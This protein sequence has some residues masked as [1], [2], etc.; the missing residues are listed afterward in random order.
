MLKYSRVFV[1]LV[2]FLPAFAQTATTQIR[3]E[4]TRLRKLL[5][6]PFSSPDFPDLK[7]S[8]EGVLKSAEDALNKGRIYLS[9]ERLGQAVDLIE[10]ARSVIERT[11]AMKGG[12]PAFE[13]E[14]GKASIVLASLDKEMRSQRW[15]GAPAAVV[16]LAET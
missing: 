1:C 13:A 9:L 6:Q 11:D 2:L 7:A 8:T 10:G 12:L 14:W 5:E 16:A 15:A 3:D 4:F